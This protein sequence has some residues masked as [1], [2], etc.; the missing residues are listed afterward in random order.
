MASKVYLG[1]LDTN[2]RITI[3]KYFRNVLNLNKQ[4]ILRLE[5]HGLS[6]SINKYEDENKNADLDF[7]IDKYKVSVG[8]LKNGSLLYFK[9]YELLCGKKLLY[10]NKFNEKTIVFIITNT[11]EENLKLDII[12]TEIIDKIVYL[13]N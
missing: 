3:P 9:N 2:G 6:I 12:F 13:D 8:I 4:S 5:L 7:L 11:D 1:K 10:I